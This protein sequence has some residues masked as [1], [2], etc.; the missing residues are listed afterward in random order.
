MRGGGSRGPAGG[1]RPISTPSPTPSAPSCATPAPIHLV[2]ISSVV[3]VLLKTLIS[4]GGLCR[5][6]EE[7]CSLK[8]FFRFKAGA[9]MFWTERD[10][11]W[12][13]QPPVLRQFNPDGTI[14]IPDDDP[15]AT[16]P[17]M[18]AFLAEN[19]IRWRFRY[20]YQYQREGSVRTQRL[21][22]RCQPSDPPL[23]C[24]S[25]LEFGHSLNNVKRRRE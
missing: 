12:N 25:D 3:N 11:S 6:V 1:S 5:T 21:K 14:Q 15:I 22:V 23:T 7:L 16:D 10:P 9:G 4:F 20:E 19:E 18:A 24:L 13:G 8:F 2:D 17:E